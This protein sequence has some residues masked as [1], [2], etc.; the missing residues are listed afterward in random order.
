MRPALVSGKVVKEYLMLPVV[1][2]LFYILFY[3]IIFKINI[4]IQIFSYVFG[5]IMKW[6]I[7]QYMVTESTDIFQIWYIFPSLNYIFINA[8]SWK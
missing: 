8:M 6:T 1:F 7:T 4:I 2:K 3:W 5:I